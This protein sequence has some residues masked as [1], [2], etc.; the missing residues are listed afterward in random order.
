MKIIKRKVLIIVFMLGTFINYA[1]NSDFENELD[2]SKVK[3]EFNNVK[4]GQ[5]L[6]IKDE[7]GVTLHSENIKKQGKLVKTFDFSELENGNYTLELDKDFE[8]VI[9]SVIIKNNK[10]TFNEEADKII[11]KPF[12]RNEENRLMITRN[13][14]DGKP[15]EIDI[16]YNDEIIYSE[17]ATSDV[18][19]NRVYRLNKE[20][21]G[22]YL[23]IVR[24]NGR[25]YVNRFTY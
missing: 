9:Q 19:L 16:Y 12:I 23:V 22:D 21:K 3:V 25:N 18:I 4:K 14:F 2:A 5:Q 6:S 15:L 17:T 13:N 10:V 24:N 8:I 20:I 7:K 11:F 1:N